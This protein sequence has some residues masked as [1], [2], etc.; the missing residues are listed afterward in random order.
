[1]VGLGCH[2]LRQVIDNLLENAVGFSPEGSVVD[3]T[4][5][6]VGERPATREKEGRWSVAGQLIV[7][8]IDDHGA[9]FGEDASRVFDRF[10][11]TRSSD[12]KHL[13]LGLAIVRALCES[14][15]GHVEAANNSDGGARMTVTLPR[16]SPDGQTAR[17][18]AV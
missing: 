18:L 10:Y 4:L 1:M 16:V 9:G 2:R 17:P 7:I 6:V 5:S 3:V 11:T 12:G 8:S 13:G 15:G 14:A